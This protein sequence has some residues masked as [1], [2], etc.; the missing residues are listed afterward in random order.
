MLM[1]VTSSG[2]AAAICPLSKAHFESGP[3]S[4]SC[5]QWQLQRRNLRLRDGLM[6]CRGGQMFAAEKLSEGL[7]PSRV[8]L[9][10]ALMNIMLSALKFIVG[11]ASGSVSLVADAYHSG[12]D[13]A[14]DAVTMVAVNAPPAWERAATLSIA[15]LLASAGATMAWQS[16]LSMWRRQLPSPESAMGIPPLVVAAFCIITKELLFRITRAVGQRTR[17]PVLFAAAKHHR[18]DAMSSLAAAVGAGGVLVGLPIADTI[19]AGVVG[20]MMFSMGVQ[21]A[22]G[23]HDGE[24]GGGEH[25]QEADVKAPKVPMALAR[26]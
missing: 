3:L 22:R 6:R 5:P 17:Q 11:T 7:S 26:P 4:A 9:L 25:V 24:H 13:L 10:G 16:C 12:S 15:A 19:A 2:S 1:C 23:N 21:V 20:C 14:V 18:S 8:T